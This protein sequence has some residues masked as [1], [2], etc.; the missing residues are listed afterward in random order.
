MGVLAHLPRG[1]P[2]N[3]GHLLGRPNSISERFWDTFEMVIVS[4]AVPPKT[5]PRIVPS[6]DPGSGPPW[7]D[8]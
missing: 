1:F 3:T 2:G 8:K 4:A 5:A 7:D 6:A